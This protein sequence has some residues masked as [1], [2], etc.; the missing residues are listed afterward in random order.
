MDINQIPEVEKLTPEDLEELRRD[1]RVGIEEHR[2]GLST[3]L[4]MQS[5]KDQVFDKSDGSRKEH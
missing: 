1:V 3:P 2:R 5:I 4:D